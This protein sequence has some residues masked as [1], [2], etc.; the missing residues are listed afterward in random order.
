MHWICPAQV[1]DGQ[2]LRPDTALGIEGGVVQRIDQ[3]RDLPPQAERISVGGTITAG[4]VD[5]Q[6]NGGGGVLFNNAPNPSGLARI[7]AAH[8]V[9]GT[10]ALLPTVI[11]DAP[12]VLIRAVDVVLA[13]NDPAVLG[14]HIEGPHIAATRRGTHDFRHIRPLDLATITQIARLIS[15]GMIAKITLAPEAVQPDQVRQLVK[16]GAI[17]SIGHSDA[18]AQQTR[19]LL[20][21]G[22][23][24]FTHLY[25]AMSPMLGRAAGVTGT[26]ISSNAYCGIICDGHHVG[27]DMVALA[28]RARPIAD[29]MFLVSDAMA[30]VGGVDSFDLYGRTIYLENGR[31]INGEGA[32]AGAHLTMLWALQRMIEYVH[33][34]AE[35]A[36]KMAVSNPC[37]LIGRPDLA[38]PIGRPLRDLWVLDANWNLQCPCEDLEPK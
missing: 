19:A 7:V 30:T 3:I 6:V 37:A 38:V 34:S 31:L 32:L 36:L 13:Q 24:C 5:L 35:V 27:N 11:T 26:A 12:E 4:F 16:M 1:F 29:R 23:N 25:N 22:A 10:V 20:D 14:L 21:E 18:T 2:T 8:R 33:I 28:I 15:A 9:F 17:V